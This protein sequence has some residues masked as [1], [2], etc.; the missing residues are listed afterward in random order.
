MTS[1]ADKITFY[2][3]PSGGEEPLSEGWTE[4]QQQTTAN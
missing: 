1:E 4:I 2:G 3:F